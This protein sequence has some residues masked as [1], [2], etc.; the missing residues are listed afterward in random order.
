MKEPIAISRKGIL[1]E[2]DSSDLVQLV[3][4][5]TGSSPR[6]EEAVNQLKEACQ[7]ALNDKFELEIIDVLQTP[8]IAEKFK[9]L[10]TPTVVKK[11][12]SPAKRLVGD[13]SDKNQLIYALDLR[14]G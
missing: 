2:D 7:E 4:F 13:L 5:I 1:M 14:D 3:L 12:P 6:A 11:L 9:V 10:A 8:D